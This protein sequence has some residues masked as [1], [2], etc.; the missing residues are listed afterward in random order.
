M[1]PKGESFFGLRFHLPEMAS[2]DGTLGQTAVAASVLSRYCASRG[3]RIVAVSED[4]STA[5]A[6]DQSHLEALTD[7]D[8]WVPIDPWAFGSGDILTSLAGD[9]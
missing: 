8:K 1:S 2:C 7:P 3:V 6:V 9:S 5:C 4:A